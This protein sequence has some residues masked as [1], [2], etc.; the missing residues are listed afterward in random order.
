DGTP[1]PV[2]QTTDDYEQD[3]FSQEFQITGVS[4]D[5]RLRWTGGLYY[6]EE[7]A[8][9]VG[10][11]EGVPPPFPFVIGGETDN[12]TFAVYGEATFDATDR[13]HLT[14][15]LRYTDETKRFS[16]IAE[17]LALN[18]PPLPPFQILAPGERSIDI[19]EITYRATVAY[20]LA[21]SVMGY[22]T[23]SEGFKSGGFVIRTTTPRP[24]PATFEPEFVTLFEAGL[25]ADFPDIGLRLNAA[26]FFSDYEDIQVAANP[27]GEIGTVTANAADG[28]IKGVELEFTYVPASALLISGA[29]G[30]QDAQYTKV[31]SNANV[32]VTLN[33]E[34]IRTP[35]W[36]WNLGT[37]YLLELGNG[38]SLTPRLDW[39]YK[40]E[41]HFE[42]ANNVLVA[43]DAYHVL[44][45]SATYRDSTEKWR[46][47]LGVNNLTDEDYLIAADSNG[48]IGYALGVFSRPRNWYLS[49]ERAF[50]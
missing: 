43:Q 31:N 28:E 11:I 30:Y 37:S 21:D 1:F 18:L 7:A 50:E 10:L 2:F 27:P 38:G 36:S 35:E 24:D 16:P 25:K 46:V 33:D 4:F 13:L 20:D 29:L 23:V 3:Q 34:F 39:V 6:F 42:P 17:A 14:A 9:D 12:D 15:G 49:V 41:T 26:A 22:F 48:A 45:V 32:T 44:N 40:A 8:S 47:A 5:E 19:S